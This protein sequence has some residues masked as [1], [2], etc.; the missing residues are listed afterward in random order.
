MF[1]ILEKIDI[2]FGWLRQADPQAVTARVGARGER[3]ILSRLRV[4][5]DDVLDRATGA[6]KRFKTGSRDVNGLSPEEV[7]S[8]IRNDPVWQGQKVRLISCGTGCWRLANSRG[9]WQWDECEECQL[10]GEWR[11]IEPEG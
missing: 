4:L 1:T 11:I 6:T 3:P 8:Q 7:A 9:R 2:C 5:G 10:S